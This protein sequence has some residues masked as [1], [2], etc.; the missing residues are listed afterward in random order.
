MT[1]RS[2]LRH[3]RPPA[4]R[5]GSARAGFTLVELLVVIAIIG[6]LV[7]LLL[8]AVQA[9]R[10]A[11]RR[12]NC[13]SNLR[14]MGLA[15]ALYHDSAKI[16]PAGAFWVTP[17][18]QYELINRGGLLVRLLPYVEEQ[19]LYDRFDFTKDTDI[20]TMVGTSR[21][22]STFPVAVY[23][24]PSDDVTVVTHERALHNY[25]GS[26]GPARHIDNSGC[27]CGT[28]NTWNEQFATA[29]YEDFRT[30]DD[31]PGMFTRISLCTR[32]SQVVDGLS[33]TIFMGEVRPMCSVHAANGWSVSNNGQGLVS[34]VVPL[35]YDSCQTAHPDGCRRPCNWNM[36]LGFKS[37]HP[38][39]AHIL[40]GDGSIH[41]LGDYIDMRVYQLLGAKSDEKAVE[42]P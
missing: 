23:R 1:L 6:I 13:L 4:H 3:N 14:Q 39:G 20:Q 2:H 11:A 22:L 30:S 28:W 29:T 12:A 32:Q 34:T 26:K 42:V 31:Y 36:E 8:P 21:L 37:A 24:C 19:A 35:N 16:Y 33:K 38:G 25:A 27:S 40:M 15:L 17:A 18:P 41:F 7:A 10:E 9:A 5:T